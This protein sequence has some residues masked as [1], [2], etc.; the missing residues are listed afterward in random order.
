MSQVGKFTNK[1][2]FYFY[3][4]IFRNVSAISSNQYQGL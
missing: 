4:I 2:I 3:T 1:N